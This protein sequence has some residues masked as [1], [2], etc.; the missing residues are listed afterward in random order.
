MTSIPAG[1]VRSCLRAAPEYNGA[2][3]S[4]RLL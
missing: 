1:L 3:W 4:N 2:Q